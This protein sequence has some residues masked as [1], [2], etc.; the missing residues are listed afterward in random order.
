MCPKSQEGNVPDT[1]CGHTQAQTGLHMQLEESK[2]PPSKK[3]ECP[4]CTRSTYHPLLHYILECEMTYTHFV[5]DPEAA[6]RVKV[7]H[8]MKDQQALTTFMA[9]HPVPR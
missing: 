4:S 1:A 9:D 7:N 2:P 3:K 6:S 5:N 8:T